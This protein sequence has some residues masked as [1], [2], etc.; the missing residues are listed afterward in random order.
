MSYP[1]YYLPKAEIKDNVK[2][3]GRNVFDQP[4]IMLKHM[5]IL[6]KLPLGKEMIT[7]LVESKIINWLQ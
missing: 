2:I 1:E 7:K 3:D 4:I 5:K 6:E